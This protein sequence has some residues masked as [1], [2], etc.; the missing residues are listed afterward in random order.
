MLDIYNLL[1]TFTAFASAIFIAFIALFIIQSIFLNKFNKLVYG[2]GTLL[3]W[4]PG[5]NLY[6]L[7]KI[8]FNKAIGYILVILFFLSSTLVREV[9]GIEVSYSFLPK[10]ISK[11]YSL[12]IIF[13]HIYAVITYIDLK[14]KNNSIKQ[15]NLQ[16]IN[17]TKQ[18]VDSILKAPPKNY[19]NQKDKQVLVN[20]K[21]SFTSSN[22]KETEINQVK[23]SN[24]ILSQEKSFN[25]K[26]NAI[27]NSFQQQNPLTNMY[28]S[29]NNY[30]NKE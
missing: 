27:N 26:T 28:N 13:L 19:N 23:Q 9:N 1:A 25:N 5:V 2:K 14:K 12:G 6:I 30:Q 21:P 3:A 8:M 17:T 29:T 11:L 22:Q 18:V 15:E 7:G 24:A 16:S 10:N 20:E 4:I